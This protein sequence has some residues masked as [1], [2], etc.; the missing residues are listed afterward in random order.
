MGLRYSRILGFIH[1]YQRDGGAISLPPKAAGR[2]GAPPARS[3]SAYTDVEF[4]A[5]ATADCPRAYDVVNTSLI[6][7]GE[8]AGGRDAHPPRGL[9]FST[10]TFSL[11]ANGTPRPVFRI[12]SLNTVAPWGEGW[13]EGQPGHLLRAFPRLK[14]LFQYV[15]PSFTSP[16]V[17]LTRNFNDLSRWLSH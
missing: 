1:L 11:D 12:T 13:G 5:T 15:S 9:P 3:L 17:T 6:A 2:V 7:C 16:K 10:T 8:S 14:G 4:P